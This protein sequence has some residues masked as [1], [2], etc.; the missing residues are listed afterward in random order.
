LDR[1]HDLLLGA[2]AHQEIPFE[3]LIEELNPKR[4]RGRLPLFQVVLNFQNAPDLP[5]RLGDLAVTQ[6]DLEA[7]IPAQHMTTK[8][9]LTAY[10]V[11][12][13]D[14][15]SGR[16]AYSRDLFA[17][18]TVGDIAG[19][20]ESLLESLVAQPEARLGTLEM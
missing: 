20:F 11:R 2:Y 7:E 6:L 9:D 18:A 15:L 16:L 5:A 4:S 14:R 13:G 1:V 10:I 3:E 17:E 19:R 8:Y 12:D